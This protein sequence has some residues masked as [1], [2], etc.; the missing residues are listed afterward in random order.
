MIASFLTP[1]FSIH[2]HNKFNVDMLTMA[3]DFSSYL[4]I[5]I[6]IILLILLWKA[7]TLL[8]SES[9]IPGPRGNWLLGQ[10]FE[11][12]ES[13]DVMQTFVEWG[14]IYGPIVEFRPL[15]IFGKHVLFR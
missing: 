9:Q 2:D 1:T 3:R 8:F 14:K 5:L 7:V 6:A 10:L 11:L 4:I 12:R 13:K 15:G